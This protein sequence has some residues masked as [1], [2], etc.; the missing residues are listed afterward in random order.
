[1]DSITVFKERKKKF[2]QMSKKKEEGKALSGKLMMMMTR[3]KWNVSINKLTLKENTGKIF[4]VIFFLK[5]K[6]I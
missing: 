3:Q 1:M 4:K 2:L 5:F 6:G